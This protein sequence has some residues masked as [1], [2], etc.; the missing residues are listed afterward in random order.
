LHA[1]SQLLSTASGLPTDSSDTVVGA[2]GKSAAGGV[3][4]AGLLNLLNR[5]TAKR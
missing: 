1:G 3:A 2:A 4:I 5:I